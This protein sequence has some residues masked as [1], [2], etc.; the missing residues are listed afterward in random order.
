MRAGA[1]TKGKR[2]RMY[3]TDAARWAGLRVSETVASAAQS[4]K[5]CAAGGW[6]GAS[7][8][9]ARGGR[10]V[11]RVT[12]KTSTVHVQVKKAVTPYDSLQLAND[13]LCVR[14]AHAHAK[15]D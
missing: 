4:R 12:S 15:P 7:W 11:E 1:F 8:R 5:K 13:K 2:V 10:R 3:D 9:R 6:G 14:G